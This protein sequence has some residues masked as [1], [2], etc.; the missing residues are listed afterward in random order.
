MLYGRDLKSTDGAIHMKKKRYPLSQVEEIKKRRLE[1]AERVLKEKRE[2]LDL[3][4]KD[5]KEKRKAL[6]ATKALKLEMIE[7]YYEEIKQGTTS[8][9]M[10][11]H[12]SYIR[13]VMNVKLAEE[14]KKV[15]DQKKVVKEATFAL[16]KAREDRIKKNQELEKIH[17]HKKEW[18]KEVKKEE[19]KD[20]SGVS[21]EL[22]TSM[23][24]RKMK[25]RQR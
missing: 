4:E 6:N 1:E 9:M 19:S 8:I 17:M 12:D 23:H 7:K 3:A 13:E 15:D 2:A 11:R 14:K 25:K 22:G 21:D 18:K 5:L 16:E 24:A 10:E 20:E